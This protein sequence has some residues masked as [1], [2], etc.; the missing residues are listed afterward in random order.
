MVIRCISFTSNS[1]EFRA[2]ANSYLSY[3]RIEG[4]DGRWSPEKNENDSSPAQERRNER[5]AHSA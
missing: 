5:N 1:K 3:M 4:M 2:R